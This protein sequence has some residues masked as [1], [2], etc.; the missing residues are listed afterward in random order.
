[1]TE[2]NC[3]FKQN[4][5]SKIEWLIISMI[6]MWGYHHLCSGMPPGL[7]AKESKAYVQIPILFPD[8]H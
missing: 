1:M 5:S 2:K 3:S 6:F 7:S 8:I 4:S